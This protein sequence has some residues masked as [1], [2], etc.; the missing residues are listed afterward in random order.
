[1]IA[2]MEATVSN[3]KEYTKKDGSWGGVLTLSSI[4]EKR[5]ETMEIFFS[6]K[7]LYGYLE[8]K[9]QEKCDIVVDLKDT[10]FG[11]KVMGILSV[12]GEDI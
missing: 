2:S 9:L 5:M 7:K 10:K 4:V 12:D 11:L 1:M 8:G 6:E 3:V